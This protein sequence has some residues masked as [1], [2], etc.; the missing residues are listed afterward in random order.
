[1]KYFYYIFIFLIISCQS[2]EIIDNQP[3]IDKIDSLTVSEIIYEVSINKFGEITDTVSIEK[4]KYNKNNILLHSHYVFFSDTYN[5]IIENYYR[6]NEEMFL[7]KSNTEPLNM[8]Y[9]Y[10]TYV[11]SNNVI[12]KSEMSVSDEGE[13]ITF[14][15]TY[16]YNYD[17][18]GKKKSLMVESEVDSIKSMSFEKYNEFEKKV[19]HYQIINNDT[20]ESSFVVYQNQKISKYTY[21]YLNHKRIEISEY[22]EGT[23]IISRNI[24]KIENKDTI[25]IEKNIFIRDSLGVLIEK[26]KFDYIKDTTYISKFITKKAT[27]NIN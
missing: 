13:K 12:I 27:Q 21:N 4:K 14:P 8:S 6:D 5:K 17:L 23:N 22:N 20:T 25:L 18:F 10:I 15:M 3:Q 26:E 19:Y 7:Q 24:Y 1:M 16:N 9:I 2:N 11:N